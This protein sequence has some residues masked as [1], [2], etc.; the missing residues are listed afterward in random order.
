M[1]YIVVVVDEMAD[2]MALCRADVEDAITRLS[3]LARAVGIHLV[4]ATQRPSVDVLTGVIK[5]NFPARISFQVASKFDSRTILDS[6][7]SERLTGSGDM[8]YLK[9]GGPKPIRIQGAFISDEEVAR[10]MEFQCAHGESRHRRE[11]LDLHEDTI[12]PTQIISQRKD[13][14]YDDAI[15]VVRETGQASIT[16][17][18]R[19]LRIGYA[20]AANIIDT[21]ELE[22]LIGPPQG[23]K[24]RDILIEPLPRNSDVFQD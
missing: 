3:Q 15:R 18:Q 22:G 23:S 10:L 11:L 9:P 8:L 6:I 12:S 24:P 21:M 2:L 16:M 4:V 17:L 20:R 19:R 7:G 1:T 5:N 14:L 13:D